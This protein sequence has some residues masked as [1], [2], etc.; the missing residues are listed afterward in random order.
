[1]TSIPARDWAAE[2]DRQTA[3]VLAQRVYL[4]CPKRLAQ[5]YATMGRIRRDAE[6]RRA[7]IDYDCPWG[8]YVPPTLALVPLKGLEAA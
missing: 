1:M 6:T 5:D 4:C 3:A 2:A 7:G 8:V